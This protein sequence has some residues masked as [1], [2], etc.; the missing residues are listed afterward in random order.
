MRKHRWI[1]VFTLTAALTLAACGGGDDEGQ[2]ETGSSP[3]AAVGSSDG[4]SPTVGAERSPGP[5]EGGQAIGSPSAQEQA[6]SVN[7]TTPHRPGATGAPASPVDD[8][9][10]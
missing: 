6:T 2:S 5:G 7:D 9:D 10:S 1:T 8:D 4:I 3:D